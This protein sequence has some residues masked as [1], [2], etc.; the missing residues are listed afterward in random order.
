MLKC[1]KLFTKDSLWNP[2]LSEVNTAHI[3]TLYFFKIN[4]NNIV[5]RICGDYIK[6]GYWI[7]NWIY[8]ITHS[9]TQLQCIHSY[10][11][12][13]FT[14]TLAESSHCI[15]TGFLS[16]NIAG[17]VRLQLCNS[18]LKTAARPEHTLVTAN[19]RLQSQSHITTDDQSGS[20]SWFRAP[21][22]AH[23]HMLITG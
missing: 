14:I 2:D 21:S 17:S 22:G 6:D 20:A 7:D 16:S 1:F 3:S 11:S 15:F 9:Y 19:L 8:W 13:Q 10:S 5:S 23:D 12:L 4:F 18:S